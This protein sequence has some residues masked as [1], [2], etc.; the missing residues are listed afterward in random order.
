MLEELLD[1]GM[2]KYFKIIHVPIKMYLFISLRK[3][4]NHQVVSTNNSRTNR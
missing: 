3:I 2:L 1:Y 4:I